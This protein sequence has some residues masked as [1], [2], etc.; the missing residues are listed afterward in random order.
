M[1]RS[2]ADSVVDSSD[3]KRALV[4]ESAILGV[5]ELICRLMEELGVSKAELA[6][7]LDKS[8]AYVTQILDGRSNLTVRSIADVLW[9]LGSELKVNTMCSDE[10]TNRADTG[11]TRSDVKF[12]LRGDWPV[13]PRP[14]VPDCDPNEGVQ[15]D[16][17]LK[18]IA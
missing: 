9:A 6:R 2:W 7:R 17:R 16:P 13:A 15:Q 3:S 10:A 14:Q 11:A 5:T 8:R 18:L 12:V 4:Q 1:A